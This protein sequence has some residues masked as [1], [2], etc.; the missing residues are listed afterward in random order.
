MG[1][2]LIGCVAGAVLIE[3]YRRIVSAAGLVDVAIQPKPDYVRMMLEYADPLYVRIAEKLRK[4][5]TP[6]DYITSVSVAGHAP[7]G[8]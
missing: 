3:E 7:N 1:E 5:Q 4:G 2:A 6:A 8:I